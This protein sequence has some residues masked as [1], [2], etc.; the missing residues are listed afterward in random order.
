MLSIGLYLALIIGSFASATLSQDVDALTVNMTQCDCAQAECFYLGAVSNA[1]VTSG[2]WTYFYIPLNNY[3]FPQPS[4]L[5]ISLPFLAFGNLQTF[6]A[7]QSPPTSSYYESSGNC[8]CSEEDGCYDYSCNVWLTNAYQGDLWIGVTSSEYD[9]PSANETSFS[10]QIQL[11]NVPYD[12]VDCTNDIP[13]VASNSFEYESSFWTTASILYIVI[14]SITALLILIAII[15]SVR[16]LRRRRVAYTHCHTAAQVNYGTTYNAV[17]AYQHV[18]QYQ[19]QQNASVYP[20][21]AVYQQQHTGF[22]QPSYMYGGPSAPQNP[23]Y[24]P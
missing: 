19:V 24:Y 8:F 18:Q 14:P 22:Q 17:P 7:Q 11:G 16:F 5:L 3:V 12:N 4:S 21:Y 13:S 10:M 15:I 1:T 20:G 2:N 23:Q 6:V 9:F